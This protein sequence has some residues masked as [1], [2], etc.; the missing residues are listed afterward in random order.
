MNLKTIGDKIKEFSI[1]T[2]KNPEFYN[3]INAKFNEMGLPINECY[4]LTSNVNNNSDGGCIL[5]LTPELDFIGNFIMNWNR[6]KDF[7]TCQFMGMLPISQFINIVHKK[8]VNNKTDKFNITLEFI[9]KDDFHL[10][11]NEVKEQEV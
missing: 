8:H 5:F 2:L 7:I 4:Y 1:N 9:K 10:E 11:M 6:N 3:E